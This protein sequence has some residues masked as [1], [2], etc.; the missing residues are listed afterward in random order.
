MNFPKKW[1]SEIWI[2]VMVF[3]VCFA[4]VKFRH[5]PA[6]YAREPVIYAVSPSADAMINCPSISI[7]SV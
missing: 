1:T 2:G 3:V 7:D 5:F 4:I 6:Y